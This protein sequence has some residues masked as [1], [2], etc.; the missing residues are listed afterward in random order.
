MSKNTSNGGQPAPRRDP[1]AR[2][3]SPRHVSGQ[4]ER[5]IS[6]RGVRRDPPDLRKLAR[7]IIAIA[8]AEM[9]AQATHEA[10]INNETTSSSG[11]GQSSE[12]TEQPTSP[13]THPPKEAA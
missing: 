11:A 4:Q 1:P 13:T 7:A 9:E 10:E 8:Q 2:G 6:V 5:R 3:R 12:V